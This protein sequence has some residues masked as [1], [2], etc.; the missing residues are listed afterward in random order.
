MDVFCLAAASQPEP[1]PHAEVRHGGSAVSQGSLAP[2]EKDSTEQAASP[3]DCRGEKEPS[4]VAPHR[5]QGTTPPLA[6][7]GSQSLSTL[8]QP[9]SSQADAHTARRGNALP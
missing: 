2:A 8:L 3:C 5:D 6:E 1:P 7:V 9:L 4:A